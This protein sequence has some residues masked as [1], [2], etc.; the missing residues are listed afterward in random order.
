MADSLILVDGLDEVKDNQRTRVVIP[1]IVRF[2]RDE[3]FKKAR[4][5]IATRP[6]FD[7]GS[8][9]VEVGFVSAVL[10]SMTPDELVEKLQAPSRIKKLRDKL[11]SQPP[12]TSTLRLFYPGPEPKWKSITTGETTMV[13]LRFLDQIGFLAPARDP[14]SSVER[15]PFLST[16][17]DL[18]IVEDLFLDAVGGN[19]QPAPQTLAEMHDRLVEKFMKLRMERNWHSPSNN[20]SLRQAVIDWI[21]QICLH[22]FDIKQPD[23]PFSLPANVIEKERVLKAGY[24][25]LL[26]KS[27]IIIM[28]Q[29]SGDTR[30]YLF[31][32]PGIDNYLREQAAGQCWSM[33]GVGEM[34]RPLPVRQYRDG[35][36]RAVSAEWMSSGF[37]C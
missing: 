14:V 35:E 28:A 15:R 22:Y 1:A 33:V 5:V 9:F 32:N 21:G 29:E 26:L 20:E 25:E 2:A 12:S 3:R 16:Y 30:L 23:K 4:M 36:P 7:F 34:R 27:E 18:G 19:L 13:F 11:A 6:T 24:L 37:C 17:R 10:P 8:P 31:D